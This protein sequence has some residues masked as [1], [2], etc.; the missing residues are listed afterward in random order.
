MTKSVEF[1]F[2]AEAAIDAAIKS[3]KARGA[4]LDR[5]IHIAATTIIFGTCTSW[6]WNTT[7]LSSLFAALPRSA[8]RKTFADWVDFVTSGMVT[9]DVKSGTISLT[10]IKD[11]EDWLSGLDR[12]EFADMLRDLPFWEFSP[13]RVPPVPT[14]D[15]LKDYVSKASKNKQAD[16]STKSVAGSLA[17]LLERV[18]ETCTKPDGEL[19]SSRIEDVVHKLLQLIPE[20]K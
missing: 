17:T 14:I 1:E 4:T 3:I 11:R 10:K 7:R 13:A 16:E 5:D 12:D 2:L 15:T 8:K 9:I 20:P 19:D 6:T 18:K